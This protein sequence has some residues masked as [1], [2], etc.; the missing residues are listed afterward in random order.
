M[1]SRVHCVCVERPAG[2]WMYFNSMADLK[3]RCKTLMCYTY[4]FICS[5][6]ELFQQNYSLKLQ[7][8][9]PGT[10]LREFLSVCWKTKLFKGSDA[11]VFSIFCF[12]VKRSSKHLSNSIDRMRQRNKSATIFRLRVHQR[13]FSQ[14]L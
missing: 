7:G 8:S 12:G 10:R 14:A 5:L 4:T 13:V 9:F 3:G 2:W 1:T 6:H 11:E